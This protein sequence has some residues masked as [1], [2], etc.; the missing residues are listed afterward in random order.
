M[1]KKHSIN[2]HDDEVRLGIGIQSQTILECTPGYFSVNENHEDYEELC[3]QEK[4]V[5]FGPKVCSENAPLWRR[6]IKLA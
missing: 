2:V 6:P 1:S 3:R 4:E 5:H